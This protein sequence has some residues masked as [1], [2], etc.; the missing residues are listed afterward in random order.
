MRTIEGFPKNREKFVR[1]IDFFKRVLDICG[2]LKINP[3]LDGSLAV[4]AYTNSQN[5]DVNDVDLSCP[6]ADFS[7][8][9]AVLE[10]KEIEYK[11]REW[12]VLQILHGDLKVELGAVEYWLEGLPVELETLQIDE[13]RVNMLGLNSLQAF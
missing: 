2:D 9:I 7:R 13:Y 11:L 1:L 3:I 10:E 8:I 12:H 5:M 4:F 6:E